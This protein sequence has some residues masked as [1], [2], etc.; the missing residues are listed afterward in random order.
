MS[1]ERDERHGR[2]GRLFAALV[3]TE[4][5]A[6]EGAGE[7]RDQMAAT[8][9]TDAQVSRLDLDALS[10]R[11]ASSPNPLHVLRRFVDDV[12]E[13]TESAGAGAAPSPLETYLA[14]RLQEAG[15]AGRDEGGAIEL[16]VVRPRTSDL[17]YL[18]IDEDELPYSTKLRVL[19]VE[20]ALNAA[21]LA[22]RALDD[23]DSAS[24][25]DLVRL[26]ARCAR[27]ITAQAPLLAR[28]RETP[29]RGEWEV[30]RALSE[31][32]ESARLPYRLTARFRVNVVGRRAAFEIDLVPPRIWWA[33][34]FV[35]G[36]GIVS[37]TSEMRRRAASDYNLRLGVL[38]A[39]Y[40]LLVAPE[41]D[42]VWVA[43]VEDGPVSHACYYSARL[44]RAQL[45]G[46]DLEGPLDVWGLM[47][48]AGTTMDERNLSLAPV[49][50]DFSLDDERLCPARRWE[51]VELSDREL[52]PT[53][54]HELGA[55]RECDLGIDE[56]AALRRAADELARGLGGSTEQNVR[57]LLSVS[58]GAS[59]DVREA[60]LRC[61]GELIDGTLEDD[62]VAI[63][64]ALVDGG[65]LERGVE[66]AREAFY[67]RDVEG[68]ERRAREA[69][70]VPDDLGTYAD[71]DGEAWRSFGTYADRVLYNRLVAPAG[72][73][74]R[75][76]P[77]AYLEGHL[78]V[79]ACAL[80]RG[81]TAEALAHAR[82]ARELAPLSAQ[83]SLHLAQCL[84][85]AGE[86]REAADELR[87][88]LSLAH[89][90]ETIGLGY[91]RMAQLQWQ[92]GHVL[93]AQACYQLACAR[94]GAP[95]LVA[96][97]AVVALIGHVGGASEASLTQEQVERALRA[98][99]IPLA[100]T[101]EVGEALLGASRSAV[102]AELFGVSRD[103]V[104]S[105]CSVM[106]DDVLYGV[107]RSLED[108]PDR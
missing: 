34:T 89:D 83:A 44:T 100:P 68:A 92:E 88:L 106:R 63:L 7:N 40:A 51:P 59:D 37:T 11:L 48:A 45:E 5:E 41:L 80:A 66:R 16:R 75:L 43:G 28:R 38:L 71:R 47:R 22:T 78:I 52:P 39:G 94:L 69:V 70:S 14:E 3:G 27:S 29:A 33:T 93:A 21:L 35:D 101:E 8:E 20:A 13:R 81:D 86:A 23:P 18:R 26:E 91:L 64:E 9:S 19:R 67:A 103:V 108:E 58:E 6:A 49:R 12:R 96:G 107:L 24:L 4:A 50:Q 76:A 95:V 90:P 105:L 82:L 79:S 2:L 77:D 56:A 85:A 61:V 74:C 10:Q 72:E 73:T 1:E 36:L 62:P 25:E 57:A 87:R 98:E 17:F 97:L 32:I 104:R 15:V 55:A 102:D 53:S 42:E 60:A 84:E 31:A 65:P 54:A 30:R 99:D 46:V